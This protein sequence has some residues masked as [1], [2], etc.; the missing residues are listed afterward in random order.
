MTSVLTI[1]ASGRVHHKV[2]SPSAGARAAKS[3]DRKNLFGCSEFISSVHR[4][5][6]RRPKVEVA[7]EPSGLVIKSDAVVE[8]TPEI[9]RKSGPG[10]RVRTFKGLR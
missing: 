9:N 10:W 4:S 7:L 3:L 1:R 2:S 6:P 5:F 8:R